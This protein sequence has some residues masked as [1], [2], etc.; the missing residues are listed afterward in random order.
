MT[1]IR[2]VERNGKKYRIPIRESSGSITSSRSR[3]S[4][5]EGLEN[6]FRG[7]TAR[8]DSLRRGP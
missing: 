1:K 6:T 4:I 5:L 2:T 3:S 7:H 8:K